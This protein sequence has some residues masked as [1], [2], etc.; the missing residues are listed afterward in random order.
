M[1]RAFEDLVLER[2]GGDFVERVWLTAAIEHA[3]DQPGV[4]I[5]LV[6][7]EPG[8]GKTSL[9]A[10]L[11]RTHSDWL[12]YFVGAEDRGA[13][14][15]GDISSFLLS[16]GHQ[17][18]GQQP[19]LYEP[20]ALGMTVRQRFGDIEEQG[21]ATGIR[22]A[23]LTVSPFYRTARLTVEV[24]QQVEKLAGELIGVEI[25]VAHL[26]PR[27]L[28]P[29]NLAHLA[30]FGPAAVLTEADPNGP[31]VVILLDA[32]DE[33]SRADRDTRLLEWLATGPRLPPNVKMVVTSRPQ[34]AL[35]LLRA[36]RED[37]IKEIFVDTGDR[38]V[39]DDLISYA[40]KTLT[41]AEVAGEAHARGLFP[42]QFLRQ[43]ARRADGNFLYLASYVRA[44]RGAIQAGDASLVDQLFT[45]EDVPQTLAGIY[46]F[47]VELA[48]VEID[49]LGLLDIQDPIGA[50]DRFTSAWEGVGQPILGV[51]TV[52]REPLT[53]D[54]LL[55]L[56]E[57]RVWPRSVR[58]V[59][60]RLRWLL[61]WRGE[62]V[63]LFHASVGEFL[64][65]ALARDKHPDCWLDPLEW[66]E[67]I[68]RH[69]R[70]SAATW[71]EAEWSTMDRYGLTYLPEH[72][73][74]SRRQ[75]SSQ[76]VDLVCPGLLRAIVRE[77]GAA[78]NFLN[79]VDRVADH[80]AESES[81]T[82]GLPKVMYLRTVREEAGRSSSALAPKV[83][84]L[85]AR[86]GRLSAAL[87]HVAGIGP[88]VHQFVAMAEIWRHAD[89]G[90]GERSRGELRELLV[91][92]ALTVPEDLS[93][94][95]HR[96][97]VRLYAIQSAA[98]V[99]APFDLDRALRLWR[100]GLTGSHSDELDQREP[101]ALYRAAARV[102]SDT[103]KACA[104][105]GRICGERWQDYLDL[106]VRAEADKAPELLRKSEADLQTA[107]AA[108][109]LVG[110]ARLAVAWS[111]RDPVMSQ[112]LLA[113]VRAEVFEVDDEDVRK[114]RWN[115]GMFEDLLGCLARTATE[116]A[117]VDQTTAR[118]LL[119]RMD[120]SS[121]GSGDACLDGARL[122]RR[123]GSPRRAQALIDRYRPKSTDAWRQ[124]RVESALGELNHEK[125]LQLIGQIYDEIPAP[126]ASDESMDVSRRRHSLGS[127]AKLLADYDLARAAQVA[128]E[129]RN[130]RWRDHETSIRLRQLDLA[131]A[132]GAQQF[133]EYDR[134]SFL[135]DIAHLHLD[136]GET[137]EAT[138][139]LEDALGHATRPGAMS[140]SGVDEGYIHFF[141]ERS[142]PG[143]VLD[144]KPATPSGVLRIA[145]LSDLSQEWLINAKRHFFRDPVDM[146]RTRPN[147]P[148]SLA[149][150]VRALAER[151][152]AKDDSVALAV[153]RA[154]E[155]P[156]ER[157]I[158]LARLHRLAHRSDASHGPE[159]DT[160][161]QE[162][163]RE[164]PKVPEYR[165]NV[166]GGDIEDRGVTA[167][168]RPD[169]RVRFELAVS[170]L[171]CRPQDKEA[172]QGLRYLSHAHLMTVTLWSSETYAAIRRGELPVLR[173]HQ[174]GFREMHLH[175]LSLS[176]YPDSSE[177][178]A[179]CTRAAAAYQEY[180]LSQQIPGYRSSLGNLQLS[181]PVYAAAVDLLRPTPGAS[182]PPAFV[183]RIRAMVGK[184][185]LPAAA[186]L[187]A[188]AAE[189][190]PACEHEL[191]ELCS[192]IIAATREITP[193]RRLDTL[194]ILATSPLLGGV[195]DPV[196][197]LHEAERC[198]AASKDEARIPSDVISRLFPL[199]L[200]RNPDVALRALYSAAWMRA[201]AML[202][203][204]AEALT[205]VLGV[206][207]AGALASAISRGRDCTSLGGAPPDVVGGVNLA[208]LIATAPALAGGRA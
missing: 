68:A 12:R 137:A 131:T 34:S 95:F 88:S 163:D 130:T 42:D 79:A 9:M 117:D 121:I 155:D 6:T 141:L 173:P 179:E 73:L 84:G 94:R 124:L 109:R 116:L 30:L 85:M 144:S 185:P 100:H 119:A 35:G 145:A 115:G 90:P 202:E 180:L 165:W 150:A 208:Q 36:G 50:A 205:D 33:A 158:G 78:G 96:T 14:A 92:T 7:G 53:E 54:Q 204:A 194:V 80:V 97:N 201:T 8:T 196:E 181:E 101:D 71:A 72:V 184:G 175:A 46:G 149:A 106:A 157:L 133:S 24:E 40:E 13:H 28:E 56:I 18:A 171:G 3:L 43:A 102:E 154:I 21:S 105:I 183:R 188:F 16:I 44:L 2:T 136:R 60:A 174:Q 58:N 17:L 32:L 75:V 38:Q 135:A 22:I 125:A 182:L 23:D 45:L 103:D 178:L 69:Y 151:L 114:E 48:R 120:V 197:L 186:G 20:S 199:L 148:P 132:D 52:A 128:R 67:R 99:L 76:A 189:V 89:P 41:T 198:E 110:Y 166:H 5:V 91:E 49:R 82:I 162:I 39:T 176:R 142:S 159:T 66:H 62:R 86:M 111:E 104:L 138:A 65:G 156:P 29:D 168:L 51:L 172:I 98:M 11:A 169:H 140:A 47:F 59:L 193:A 200:Y 190:K 147:S 63:A 25:G 81:P 167:Y 118:F 207:A 64:T 26:E 108:A 187:V 74:S 15:A 61:Y 160:L 134:Y 31:G 153:V 195:V 4:G 1:E 107:G 19:Q 191:V 129:L 55:R 93:P 122:W 192:E 152:W 27:L 112:R 123:F 126:R 70:G 83:V 164:L 57:A 206:N 170:S 10:G 37:Q 146:I 77:F 203:Y 177:L 113:A 143:P 127:V 87:E 139:I 161:S